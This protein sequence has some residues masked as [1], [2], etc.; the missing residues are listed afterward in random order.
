MAARKLNF[1]LFQAGSH[2]KLDKK[3]SFQILYFFAQF[4][5]EST[6][7]QKFKIALRDSTFDRLSS[8]PTK[9]SFTFAL[10][11]LVSSYYFVRYIY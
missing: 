3:T 2:K 8:A 10:S 5:L 7:P 6:K 4:V 9:L 11:Y 1:H